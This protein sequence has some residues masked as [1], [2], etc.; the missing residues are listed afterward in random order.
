MASSAPLLDN[1]DDLDVLSFGSKGK[2]K[3]TGLE[4]VQLKVEGE[5]G[6]DL[7]RPPR[8]KRICSH[9]PR[10]CG[11]G[12]TCGAC[13]ASIESGLKDQEGIASVKV[14]LL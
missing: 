12:M 10:V 2:E 6:L 1:A 3:M 13:V 7:V 14:A 5:S 9:Q 8:R 4:T 11:I